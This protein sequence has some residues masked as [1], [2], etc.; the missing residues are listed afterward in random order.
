ML[1]IISAMPEEMALLK[2]HMLIK[3]TGTIAAREFYEGELFGTP[4]VLVLSRIGKVAASMTSTLLMTQFDV[5]KIIFV[6]VAGSADNTVNIGDVVI[7]DSLIQHD[8]DCSP[9]FPCF[10]IP[11]LGKTTFATDELLTQQIK[12][13]AI[14]YWENDYQGDVGAHV[15]SFGIHNPKVHLGTIASGD[16]FIKDSSYP[17]AIKHK[18]NTLLDSPLLAFEMEGAAVA[19]C[20]YEMQVPFAVLRTISDNADHQ[21]HIDFPKFIAEIASHYSLGIMRELFQK[22]YNS[23]TISA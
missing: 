2:K 3:N 15:K 6:G 10:E 14:A 13:A 16:Q 5:R 7:A 11:L 23:D 17:A 1:G 4:I 22:F 18:A 9:L 21:A 12:T 8:M 19:Q 20:C